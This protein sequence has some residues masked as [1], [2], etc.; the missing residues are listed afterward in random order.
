MFRQG[1]EASTSEVSNKVNNIQNLIQLTKI[2]CN[3]ESTEST[4]YTLNC[5]NFTVSNTLI[6]GSDQNRYELITFVF[7]DIEKAIIRKS[8]M[9]I[10]KPPLRWYIFQIHLK[11]ILSFFP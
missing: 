9:K 8:I 6:E 4:S 5:K 11:I 3:Q 1:I 2:N 10:W 7:N